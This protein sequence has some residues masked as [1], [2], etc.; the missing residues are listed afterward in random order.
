MQEQRRILE[1]CIGWTTETKKGELRT[2]ASALPIDLPAGLVVEIVQLGLDVTPR[3]FVVQTEKG[4][5]EVRERYLAAA[6]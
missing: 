4:L 2:S 1:D 3:S 5:L 6:G